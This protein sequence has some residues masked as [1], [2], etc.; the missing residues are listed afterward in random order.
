M[1]LS[2]AYKYRLYPTEEQAT[3]LDAWQYACYEVQR[4]CI[5]Q[6]RIAFKKRAKNKPNWATQG[7]ELTKARKDPLLSHLADVPSDTILDM[8]KRVKL[9]YDVMYKAIEQGKRGKAIPKP[10]WAKRYFEVGLMF[11]GNRG[12]RLVTSTE[13][14]GYWQLAGCKKKLGLLKVRMHRQLPEGA[15]IKQVHITRG[16]DE[17]YIS[18]SCVIPASEPLPEA[19]KEV[20]GVDLGCIHEGNRQRIAA[21]DDGR[22]Y[23]I[24]DGSKR[25]RKRMTTYQRLVDP[26]RKVAKAAKV[27]DPR[28][29][30][31]KKRRK[32]I[33]KLARKA[34][35]QR[36]H[37]QQ[38]VARRLVD[39]ADTT[40]F[41]DI[42]WKALR[43]NGG[44]HKKGLNRSMATAAPSKLIELTKEK[45]Q[46]AG[47]QVVKVDPRNTS[48]ICSACGVKG[49]KKDLSVRFWECLECG[50]KHDRDI[51]AARNI[52][53]RAR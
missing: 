3:R 46:A 11:R 51:N 7:R 48:Q 20:N 8:V 37:E 49:K 28:S 33:A 21:V 10:R 13:R 27:A 42:N 53:K 19:D 4:A 26:K 22:I 38:Y 1:T 40:A 15:D 9:T 5:I 23:T 36:E 43:A 30:R 2:R 25:T 32:R 31:T 44:Q 12:T 34:A 39:T 14:Y 41:E 35:R 50:A 52:A 16:G 45:A 47:R 17:W 24:G 29:N 6:R 18:F